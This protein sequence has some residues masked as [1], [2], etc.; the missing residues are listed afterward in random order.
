MNRKGLLFI[1]ILLLAFVLRFYQLGKIPPGINLDEAAIGWNAYSILKTGRDEYGQFLPLVFRSHDD[2]KP[3][4]YIYLTVPAVAVFGLTEY[5]V[6]FP[7]ALLGVLA[8]AATYLLARELLY[9]GRPNPDPKL[10]WVVPF[11]AAFLLAIAPWHL[12]FT[13]VAFE[14]G[15]VVFMTATG[16]WL[17][18]RGL[19]MARLYLWL[20]AFL[21]FGTEL[22]LYQAARVFV[23]LF[24]LLLFWVF[25]RTLWPQRKK[26]SLPLLLFGL[27]L[28]P[29]LLLATTTAGQMRLQGTS[30]LQDPKPR[31]INLSWRFYDQAKGDNNALVLFHP[32]I[33]AYAQKAAVSYLSH[34]RPDFLFLGE[35]GP[36]VNYVANIG[37][38]YLWEMPLLL[39]GLFDVWRNHKQLA[40]LLSGWILLAPLP[41]AVTSATPSSIRTTAVLPAYQLLSAFG[42]FRLWEYAGE[43]FLLQRL[44]YLFPLLVM[45]GIILYLH[46]MLIHAPADYSQLWFYGY[47]EVVADTDRL[48][49][50]YQKIIVSTNLRQP[51]NFFTFFLRY[52][53]RTYLSQDGG[54]VSGGFRETGNHFGKYYF[55]P[56]DW[57][58]IKDHAEILAVGKPSEFPPDAPV[59][60]KYYYLNGQE[61]V[62]IVGRNK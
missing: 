32:Q 52:D 43:R 57:G 3:P 21:F 26:I 37:L 11:T 7:S 20:L 36:P 35:S 12:Q 50:K 15:S 4:L 22:Y 61:S 47:K 48:G 46:M 14:S 44:R 42:L 27:L 10:F 19:R 49:R 31:E 62:Y 33:L 30:I 18:L 53:P 16:L 24:I 41:A 40:W 9:L 1:F 58:T 38:L 54:T 45:G 28:L 13:R 55:Q 2:Y 25:F 23:P 6:R 29:T 60:K 34:F 8:V 59:L 51:Q 5:A 39:I 17:W 56:I